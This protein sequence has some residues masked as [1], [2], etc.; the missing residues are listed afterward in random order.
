MQLAKLLAARLQ[1]RLQSCR[2]AGLQ[3]ARLKAARVALQAQGRHGQFAQRGGNAVLL[4]FGIQNSLRLSR[5]SLCEDR[6][7]GYFR[8]SNAPKGPKCCKLQHGMLQRAPPPLP[9]GRR[10][11]PPSRLSLRLRYRQ[12]V[13]PRT[14]YCSPVGR[15]VM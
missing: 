14:F 1:S 2:T 10:G 5:A 6:N 13:T 9:G 7:R 15:T 11:C 3:A 4:H 12:I 8:K